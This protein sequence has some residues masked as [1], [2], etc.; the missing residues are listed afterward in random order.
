[1]TELRT[2]HLGPGEY[3]AEVDEGENTT[4]HRVVVTHGL[5]ED[6]EIPDVTE[7]QVVRESLGFLLEK[8]PNT[9][10][11]HDIDLDELSRGD[12]RYVPELQRRLVG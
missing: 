11:P 3:A 12:D 10:L 4:H 8:L 9:S 5:I 7:E 2:R 1:M 6:L